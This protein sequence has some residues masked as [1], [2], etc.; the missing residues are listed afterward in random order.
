MAVDVAVTDV[1][2]ETLALR[3]DDLEI[4]SRSVL[5]RARLPRH[6]PERG[7][8]ALAV[9][10]ASRN[11]PRAEALVQSTINRLGTGPFLY[12]YEPGGNDG[13]TGKE[14]G[15]PARLLVGRVGAGHRRT[16]R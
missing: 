11:D 9:L 6:H 13:F 16:P 12:R 4:R 1:D 14:G 3:L 7:A 10:A 8:D 5:D 2:G 15:V